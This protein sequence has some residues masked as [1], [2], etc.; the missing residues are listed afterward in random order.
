MTR[1]AHNQSHVIKAVLLLAML[2]FTSCTKRGELVPPPA[3]LKETVEQSIVNLNGRSYTYKMTGM[4]VRSYPNDVFLV[5]ADVETT[6]L[7]TADPLDSGNLNGWDYIVQKAYKDDGSTYWQVRSAR[8]KEM[9]RVLG[10]KD[11]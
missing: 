10:V 4:S 8:D 6:R 9:M 1:T 7:K 11:E 3:G 5:R 2:A